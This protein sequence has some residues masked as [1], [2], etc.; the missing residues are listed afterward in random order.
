MVAHFAAAIKVISIIRSPCIKD[1]SL[2]LLE[3]DEA[4]DP[5]IFSSC[6]GFYELPEQLLLS[7]LT[8]LM[9]KD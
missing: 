8:G 1:L 2:M 5:D 3:L 6:I 4:F 9:V 7:S